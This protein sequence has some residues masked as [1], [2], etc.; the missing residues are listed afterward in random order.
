MQ[1]CDVRPDYV[2]MTIK[3]YTSL[4]EILDHLGCK[5]EAKNSGR[6]LYKRR[7]SALGGLVEVF[8]DQ[9]A[10]QE[11][12]LCIQITGQ[13]CRM[14]EAAQDFPGW[15]PWLQMWRDRFR[16]KFTRF[17]VAVDDVDFSV[18]FEVVYD[19]WRNR[20]F[21]A[22]ARTLQYVESIKNGEKARS[23]Y[24]GSRQSFCMFRAYERGKLNG[25][26]DP[27]MR[28]E[29]EFKAQKAVEVVNVLVD[30]G[31]DAVCACCRGEVDFTDPFDER[32]VVSRREVAPWWIAIM[33]TA[34][35]SIHV[36]KAVLTALDGRF[37]SL[38]KQW[39]PTLKVMLDA[40]GGDMGWLPR[41]LDGFVHRMNDKTRALQDLARGRL[42]SDDF[43]TIVAT[44]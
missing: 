26:A 33:D 22:R 16:A 35:H 14:I 6:Y 13:A 18:P 23:V 44:T 41:V 38:V 3:D 28:F 5:F 19:H 43:S 15:R 34:K 40:H 37:K 30:Q 39:G 27:W 17:D 42:F 31:W 12:H 11:D 24:I 9:E 4:N 8:Y 21:T 20:D 25:D 36:G 32:Q 10:G 29:F 1:F 7:M 2:R